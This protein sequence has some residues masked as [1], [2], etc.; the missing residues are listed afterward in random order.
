MGPM[1]RPLHAF[2]GGSASL[3]PSL[4]LLFFFSLAFLSRRYVS[5]PSTR[6]LTLLSALAVGRDQHTRPLARCGGCARSWR[7][8]LYRLYWAFLVTVTRLTGALFASVPRS[9]IVN[10][11]GVDLI[12][13][14]HA[15]LSR[16]RKRAS[17]SA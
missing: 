13:Y 7:T 3:C 15:R 17:T 5:H 9:V 16:Y 4:P 2:R 10:N 11:R 14:L 6:P 1:A 12:L 8:T